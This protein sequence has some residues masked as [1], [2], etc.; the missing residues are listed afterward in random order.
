[1]TYDLKRHHCRS[2]RL[3]GCDYAQPGAYFVTI[4][5]QVYECWPRETV[6]GANL[7]LAGIKRLIR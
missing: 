4:A 6:N 5:T 2:I 1:V 3:R 7:A